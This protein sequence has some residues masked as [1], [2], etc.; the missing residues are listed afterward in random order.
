MYHDNNEIVHTR[1]V[2]MYMDW[3]GI[4]GGLRGVLSSIFIGILFKGFANFN[5][6]IET[7][8]STKFYQSHHDSCHIEVGNNVDEAKETKWFKEIY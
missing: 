2:L 3:L 8:N 6:M 4:I 7:L 5:S 1:K